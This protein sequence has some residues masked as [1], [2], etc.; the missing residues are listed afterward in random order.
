MAPVGRLL[1]PVRRALG[2]HQEPLRPDGHGRREDEQGVE[3][4][5]LFRL[6][7]GGVV[8]KD[9]PLDAVPL[10]RRKIDHR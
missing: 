5:E 8:R 2:R 4:A 7:N 10:E 1:V 9:V 3:I 6:E